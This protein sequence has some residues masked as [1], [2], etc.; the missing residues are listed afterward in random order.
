METPPMNARNPNPSPERKSVPDAHPHDRVLLVPPRS[1]YL[2]RASRPAHPITSYEI[3]AVDDARRDVAAWA[4]SI[5]WVLRMRS[6][7]A[8]L[9][10]VGL[11]CLAV[12]RAVAGGSAP[13]AGVL[14]LAPTMAV[15]RV[16][17][18]APAGPVRFP[19]I[20]VVQRRARATLPTAAGAWAHAFGGQYVECAEDPAQAASAGFDAW[21]YGALLLDRLAKSALIYRASATPH[22]R[23]AA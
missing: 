9:V 17:D 20:V 21:L 4:E 8:F 19:A 1:S 5:R 6:Q 11:G 13:V 22:R 18:E 2:S 3:A 15:G 14:L 10:G 7:Q 16:R 23:T 12:M